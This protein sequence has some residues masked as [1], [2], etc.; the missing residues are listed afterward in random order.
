[1]SLRG[2]RSQR[3]GFATTIQSGGKLDVFLW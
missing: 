1:V 2:C 3:A